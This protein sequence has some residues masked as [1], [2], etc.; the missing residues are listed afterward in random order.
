MDS[1]SEKLVFWQKVYFC[2]NLV[3]LCS[4]VA[5]NGF[6]KHLLPYKTIISIYL[7]TVLLIWAFSMIMTFRLKRKIKSN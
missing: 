4:I 6:K 2:F 1:N 5:A 3:G 7:A